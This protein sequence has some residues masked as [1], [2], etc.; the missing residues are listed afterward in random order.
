MLRNRY[1]TVKKLFPR[2]MKCIRWSATL[3]VLMFA[4]IFA[5]VAQ[6]SPTPTPSPRTVP[7]EDKTGPAVAAKP[8]PTPPINPKVK[9]WFDLD[10]FTVSTRYRFL[11]A[12][13]GSTV[14][15]A[16]QYQLAVRGRFK[17]DRKGRYSVVAGLYTGNSINGGWNNTGWGTGDAQSNLYLKQLYFDAKP[18]KPLQIQ[19]GGIPI[20]NGENTEITGYDNDAYITGGRVVLRLPKRVYFDEVSVIY[21]HFGEL[22]RPSVFHRFQHLD[23]SN[24]HQFLVRKQVNK[25][26]GFSA[27][28]TFENGLDTLRQAVKFKVP[29]SHILDTVLFENYQRVSPN[30]G[31]GFGL[32][33]EKAITKK[34]TVNGGFARIDIAMFNGDRYPRG[35]RIYAGGIYKF[36]R[37]F[38]LGSVIIQG[39]GPLATPTTHRTRFELIF[40]Y[41]VLETLHRLRAL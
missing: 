1:D 19:Y 22:N 16:Q 35:N 24:Y 14:G 11:K 9:R 17:F 29:E 33:G 36:N 10:A 12:N 3:S 23:E 27:D 31:Y 4:S 32:T 37:E 20:N 5:A 41:N 28:Y 30:R 21:A 6:V 38:S 2:V 25:R 34:L 39:V 18:I 13:N 7:V 8:T 40:T 26:V 15:N